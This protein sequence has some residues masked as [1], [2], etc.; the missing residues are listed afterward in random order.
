[1]RAPIFYLFIVKC[2][3]VRDYLNRCLA[4]GGLEI[5]SSVLLEGRALLGD[6]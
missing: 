4:G 3:T 6:G 5:G 2:T 1:V